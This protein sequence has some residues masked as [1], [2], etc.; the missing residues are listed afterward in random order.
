MSNNASFEDLKQSELFCRINESSLKVI[1]EEIEP[2]EIK[3]GSVLFHR[4]DTADAVY[5]VL[6]GELEDT[7][8]SEN[9]QSTSTRIIKPYMSAGEIQALRGGKFSENI[10]AR[11]DCRL[12]RVPKAALDNL[13][14][15]T[16]AD[17]Q[18]IVAVVRQRIR[19]DQ[20]RLILPE[21]FGALDEAALAHSKNNAE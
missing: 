16:P 2:I 19:E 10:H 21:F 7:K 15:H 13:S 9:G 18:K 17:F 4:G 6:Q 12:L 3:S 20:L 8:S 14:I 5:V 1:C 11:S